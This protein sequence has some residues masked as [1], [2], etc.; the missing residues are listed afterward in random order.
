METLTNDA[1]ETKRQRLDYLPVSL[2]GSVMGLVGLS[3]AWN[4]A[5]SVYGLPVVIGNGISVVAVLVFVALALSYGYKCLTAWESVK[6]E[7][8]HPISG[9]LFGTV[10]IS[11]LL[12]PIVLVH[13]SHL[14]ALGVW[15]IGA[16]GMVLF[17]WLIVSR[18][19]DN[20]QQIVHAT[21]AWIIPVVGLLDLPLAMPVLGLPASSELGLFALA[22]GLF[23]AVP[24]FTLIFAR[25]LFEAPM[26]KNQLPSLM[27]LVAPFAVGYSTYTT[28]T[29]GH[30]TF[31]A[32]LY[33]L[34]LFVLV[35]LFRQMRNLSSC[36]PFRVSWWAVSFP[37][38][39]S[40]ICALRFASANPGL[41]TDGIASLL[42]G[43]VSIVI[44]GLFLRTLKG[45]LCGELR[46]LSS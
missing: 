1:P 11:L 4:E 22:V 16:I 31:A 15:T 26:A 5:T 30:D 33:M 34:T 29:G 8:H 18:W 25:L 7:F 46:A 13:A 43:V 14:L 36:C 23:F 38:A 24:L 21:P 44:P 3:V 40:A 42:L 12:L 2:F 6:A 9:N 20:R 35:I 27:I 32:G 41:F 10:L 45:L 17:A 39:A 37:L 28:V 19:M